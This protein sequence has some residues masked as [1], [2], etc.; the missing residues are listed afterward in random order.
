MYRNVR[1]CYLAIR[2]G[3]YVVHTTKG[4]HPRSRWRLGYMAK[5]DLFGRFRCQ[6]H[7]YVG[8]FW[9]Y[10]IE[11]VVCLQPWNRH[12][13]RSKYHIVVLC[14]FIIVN[15]L[16]STESYIT[17]KLLTPLLSQKDN[18]RLLG[19]WYA[20]DLRLSLSVSSRS[21]GLSS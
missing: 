3:G 12:L 16:G 17:F 14:V 18:F 21:I 1:R 13:D 8:L 2:V 10:W 20:P 7:T 5:G 19:N 6:H 15:L 9:S 4:V 11:V